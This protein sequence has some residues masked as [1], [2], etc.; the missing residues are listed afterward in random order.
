[1][2]VFHDHC[3]LCCEAKFGDGGCVGNDQAT[4][5]TREVIG[6]VSMLVCRECLG[7][8]KTKAFAA[9]TAREANRPPAAGNFVHKN[10]LCACGS[11]RKSRH[12]CRGVILPVPQVIGPTVV[13]VIGA[14]Q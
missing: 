9:Q 6:G 11:G 14:M 3:N 13:H 8:L 1:M 2:G 12:C 5:L 4:E 7:R 10:A